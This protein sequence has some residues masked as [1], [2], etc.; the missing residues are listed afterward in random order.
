MSESPLPRRQ[1]GASGP[2][3]SAITLGTMNF[4]EQVDAA[5][6]HDLLDTAWSLGITSFDTAESYASPM[7]EATQGASER[8]LGHWLQSVPRSEVFIASKVSGPAAKLHYLRGGPKLTRDHIEQAVS[9]SLDRLK[10]DYLDL[11]QIHWPARST[12]YFGRLGYSPRDDSGA[13]P[14]RE[15]LEALAAVVESGRV[16]HIGVSNETPWGVMHYLALSNE[17]GLPR[18]QSVQNPYNLLS[19]TLEIGLAEVLHREQLGLLAYA[20]LADGVLSGKYA[21]GAVPAGTRLAMW[22]DYYDRYTLCDT[23]VVVEGYCQ[24][25]QEHNLQPATMALAWL[26]AQPGVSTAIIGVSCVQ[27]LL[28]NVR[29]ARVKLPKALRKA[30]GALHARHPNPC[31]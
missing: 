2:L 6:A 14:I 29:A 7:R 13:T 26:L 21:D 31:P 11:Y 12:N 24:I 23:K 17:F 25:A 28:D 27:Q 10:T 22:P 19:R 3:V 5:R 30:I 4:G 18:I 9:A 8:I 20:P 15:T 16:R 1:L